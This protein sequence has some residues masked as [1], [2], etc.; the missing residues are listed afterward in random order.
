MTWRFRKSFSP[1]PGV[2]LTLSPSGVSTS[3]GIGPLRVTAGPG[4][5]AFTAHIPGTGLSFR[6]PL[7][8]QRSAREGSFPAEHLG[9]GQPAPSNPVLPPSVVTG[10]PMQ[11]I[12]SAAS[13][14]LTTPGLE[15]F[16][17]VL[18]QASHEHSLITRDLDSARREEREAGGAHREWQ[19]GWLKRRVFKARFAQLAAAAEEATDRRKE[20]EEQAALAKLQTQIELPEGV[21]RAF[22]T[23]CDE[24]DKLAGSHRIWDT[25]SQR[26]ANK[27]AERT[28]ASRIIERKTVKFGLDRCAVIDFTRTIPR[29]GNANGGDIFLYPAFVLYFI[30]A[31]SFALLEY[32]DVELEYA[33]TRFIE[34]ESL[35]HDSLVVGQTWAKANKD[36]SPDRRF[37]SNRQIPVAQYGRMVLKSGTGMHEEYMVSNEKQADEFA[38]AWGRMVQAVRAGV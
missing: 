18:E 37:A 3:V 33:P 7:G 17:K 32:K 31:N 21:T 24:F 8:G 27:V 28:T 23:L 9:P 34:D 20:L 22:H 36:G 5:A 25:V 2:R 16:K 38:R 29:L 1:I 14:L 10:A 35:P 4:G 11:E 30:T 15:A 12:R 26:G 19:L 13:G 6:Q